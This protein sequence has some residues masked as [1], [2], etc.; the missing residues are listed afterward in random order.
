MNKRIAVLA[1]ILVV[2]LVMLAC[3]LP[4]FE[5]RLQQ[6]DLQTISD[7]VLQTLVAL[8]QQSQPQPLSNA[9][10]IASAVTQTVVALN[11]QNQAAQV[12]QAA[13]VAA[14]PIPYVYVAPIPTPYPCNSATAIDVTV[15]DYTNFSLNQ[16]FNKIWR[17]RNTGVCTWNT[18]YRL[19]FYGGDPLNAPTSVYFPHS[20]APGGTVDVTVPMQAP[21]YSGT[22]TGYWGLYTDANLS[23]GSVW[24]T[25]TAGSIVSPT[26][27]AFRVTSVSIL[28]YSPT[29]DCKFSATI[30]ANGAGTVTYTWRY[31]VLG[32]PHDIYTTALS[33]SGA[34]SL[35]VTTPAGL[36]GTPT[37]V[38]MWILPNNQEFGPLVSL[39]CP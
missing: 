15:D 36:P 19:A 9:E 37:D 38:H 32:V 13:A 5:A 18:G 28:Q 22:F 11:A 10:V 30:T 7:S 20:V 1:G 8:N 26:T 27:T 24:V 12:V 4:V 33:F 29:A 17:L 2:S 31:Y 34:T 21:S 39:T 14:A 25:I 16:T 6:K 3:S 35:T 23:F